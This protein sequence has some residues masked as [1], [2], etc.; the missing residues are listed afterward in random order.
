MA[1]IQLEKA[2][3]WHLKP[4]PL[5]EL[6]CCMF[7]FG[8]VWVFFWRWLHD[9]LATVIDQLQ[10]P[11]FNGQLT[12]HLHAADGEPMGSPGHIGNQIFSALSESDINFVGTKQL[13]QALSVIAG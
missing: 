5:H 12:F 9:E 6:Q 4:H 11:T 3:R 8:N 10:L 1:I 13:F 7:I 2:A